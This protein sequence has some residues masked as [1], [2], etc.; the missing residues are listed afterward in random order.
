[1]LF[2]NEATIMLTDRTLFVAPAGMHLPV[3]SA[4]STVVIEY[5]ILEG[6]KVQTQVPEVCP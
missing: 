6:Q 3:Y 4:G 2:A 1:M 5:E